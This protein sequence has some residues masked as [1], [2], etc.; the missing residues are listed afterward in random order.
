VLPRSR[1][2]PLMGLTG[3]IGVPAVLAGAWFV[4]LLWPPGSAG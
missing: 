4:L 1:L 2:I 3:G